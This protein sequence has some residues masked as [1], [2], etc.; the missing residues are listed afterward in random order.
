V[1]GAIWAAYSDTGA[2]E[3]TCPHCD[4]GPGQWCTRDDGRVRRVPCIART[5]ATGLVTVDRYRDFTEPL[6][7][8]RLRGNTA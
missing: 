6:P 4:A 5:A 8:N 3:V 7:P 2:L 1:R